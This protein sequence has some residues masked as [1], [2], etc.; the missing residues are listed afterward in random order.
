MSTRLPTRTG[1]FEKLARWAEGTSGKVEITTVDNGIAVFVTLRRTFGDLSATGSATYATASP[2]ARD[3]T[4][5]RDRAALS[6]RNLYVVL[7]QI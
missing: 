4:E 5:A 1:Y 7:R 3:A 2:D 6:A